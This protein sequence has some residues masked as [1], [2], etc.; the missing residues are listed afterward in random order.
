MDSLTLL[1]TVLF[2]LS[3]MPAPILDMLAVAFAF[4]IIFLIIRLIIFILDA[5]PFV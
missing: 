3:F 2:A 1:D 4:F 5:I